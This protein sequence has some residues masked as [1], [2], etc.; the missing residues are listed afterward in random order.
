MAEKKAVLYEAMVSAKFLRRAGG[1][2]DVTD[3][4]S[5]KGKKL[6][7]I[8]VAIPLSIVEEHKDAAGKVDFVKVTYGNGWVPFSAIEKK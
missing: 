7:E 4:P 6:D 5:A 1:L 3:I 8:R 2:I